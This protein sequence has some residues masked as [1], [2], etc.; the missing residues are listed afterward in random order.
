V[1]AA[2][3]NPKAGGVAM[4]R[5]ARTEENEKPPANIKRANYNK[6]SKF[7]IILTLFV[8]FVTICPVNGQKGR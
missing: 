7:N 8:I 5:P 2:G 3:N 4:R 6:Q 1:Q